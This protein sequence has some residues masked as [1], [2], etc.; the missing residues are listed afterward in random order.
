MFEGFSQDSTN[1]QRILQAI[2]KGGF[3][4]SNFY[5]SQ[6]ALERE[7]GLFELVSELKRTNNNS[8]Q[9]VNSSKGF[10]RTKDDTS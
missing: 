2:S 6:L 4:P 3:A 1:G 5:L 9:A 7:I 8:G 10:T